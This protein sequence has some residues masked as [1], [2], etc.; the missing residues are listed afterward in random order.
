MIE[1]VFATPKLIL[2]GPFLTI[3][4][5]YFTGRAWPAFSKCKQLS[6]ERISDR[7]KRILNRQK[8]R[9]PA[10][11]IFAV[12]QNVLENSKLSLER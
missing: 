9:V 5:I 6:C 7:I 8:D 3:A 2:D 11:F 10:L 4:E 12:L 1:K